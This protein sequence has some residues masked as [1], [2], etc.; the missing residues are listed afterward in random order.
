[1]QQDARNLRIARRPN[2]PPTQPESATPI[3]PLLT[4]TDLARILGV[5]KRFLE[6]SRSAGTFPAPDVWLGRLPRYTHKSVRAFI[7]NGGTK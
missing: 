2:D 4:P 1:M 5:S 7:A 3:D 6:R